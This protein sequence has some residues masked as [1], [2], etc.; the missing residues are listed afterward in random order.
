MPLRERL[1]S[2]H[3]GF[4]VASGAGGSGLTTEDTEDT[5]GEEMDSHFP[6]GQRSV[7]MRSFAQVEQLH[8]RQ[9]P[10]PFSAAASHWSQARQVSVRSA[11]ISGGVVVK[12][13][14]AKRTKASPNFATFFLVKLNF[15]GVICSFISS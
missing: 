12:P 5:E 3:S 2:N 11:R 1:V 6:R 14:R 4:R 10:V 8:L 7:A 15:G 13:D 9:R